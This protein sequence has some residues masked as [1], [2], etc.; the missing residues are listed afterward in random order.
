MQEGGASGLWPEAEAGAPHHQQVDLLV[1]AAAHP[2]LLTSQE[3]AQP[4]L[5]LATDQPAGGFCFWGD[6]RGGY[7]GC[8][9][10]NDFD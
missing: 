1:Q 2:R 5:L 7:W 8:M 9:E 6:G 3:L 10:G 4:P